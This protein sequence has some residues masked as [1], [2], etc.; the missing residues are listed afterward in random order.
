MENIVDWISS[1]TMDGKLSILVFLAFSA[2]LLFASIKLVK[3]ADIII[4][5]TKFGGAFIGGAFIA[6]ITSF[7]EMITEIAQS[8]SGNPGA[9][10]SDD[11]GSN[12][13]S[14]LLIAFAALLFYKNKIF[15]YVDKWTKT[16]MFLSA[17]LAFVIF[18]FL[19]LG[20]DVHIGQKGTFVIGIIPM[21]FFAFYIYSLRLTYKYGDTKE[22]DKELSI[23]DKHIS[24]KSSAWLFTFWGFVIAALSL[25]VN[26]SAS[27]MIDSYNMTSR[28][29]GG[30]FLAIITS[31]PEIIA[32]FALLRKK[33][34]MAA[35]AALIGSHM[36]N[37]GMQ[38]F[39]DMSYKNDSIYNVKEV[40][41]VWPIALMTGCMMIILAI[42]SVFSKK[43]KHNWIR[44]SIPTL[45][46]SIYSISWVFIFVF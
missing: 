29:V 36:F 46:I 39:G 10:I 44:I 45:V 28:S 35:I 4:A 3:Y 6:G 20:K 15:N 8:A 38:F 22:F 17:G 31:L 27:A 16:S 12:A 2:V 32:F 18:I 33:Q 34:S 26:W 11:L 9:G 37:V 30:I 1:W 21:I 5:K 19:I 41:A 13:F 7:P 40:Q 25:F 14:A 43:I 24:V 23:K 42:Y